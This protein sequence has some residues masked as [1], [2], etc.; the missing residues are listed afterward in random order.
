MIDFQGSVNFLD[1][2]MHTPWCYYWTSYYIL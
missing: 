1:L 2:T